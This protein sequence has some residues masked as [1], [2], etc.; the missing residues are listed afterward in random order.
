MIK[1]VIF[2]LD[3][4]LIDSEPNYFKADRTLVERYGGI[5]TEE[6]HHD[7]IGIGGLAFVS[8]LKKKKNLDQSIE[9]L[10]EEKDEIYLNIA[11]KNTLVFP[12]MLALLEEL[13]KQPIPMY[14][15]SGSSLEIIHEM[16]KSCQIDK[17]FSGIYS[18]AQ[19]EK[20]K[21]AP[22]IFLF[23][24]DKEG[25]K[26]EE[27]LVIEDSQYGVEAALRAGSFCAAVPYVIKKPLPEIYF[28]SHLLFKKGMQDFKAEAVLAF[29]L[30][31]LST[32][33]S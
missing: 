16:L 15:A 18:A 17:Y 24:A 33:N 29:I 32:E 22:D 19:V 13:A 5:F 23:T 6:M 8:W 11:R 25:F 9:Q 3:G 12:Q 4:T 30:G 7:F 2:D 1:A 21:P 28:K 26:P 14:V 20:G 27:C 10:L 31:S